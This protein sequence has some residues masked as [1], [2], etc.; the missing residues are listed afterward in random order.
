[1]SIVSVPIMPHALKFKDVAFWDANSLYAK[2][3][4]NDGHRSIAKRGDMI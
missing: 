4:L 1:M 3:A 2:M